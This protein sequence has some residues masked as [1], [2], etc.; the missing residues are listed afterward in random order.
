MSALSARTVSA[1]LLALFVGFAGCTPASPPDEDDEQN[2]GDPPRRKDVG[3][4]R[5]DSFTPPDTQFTDTEDPTRDT[6]DPP[7]S[8]GGFKEKLCA[9]GS[10]FFGQIG[11]RPS[12]KN[13][14]FGGTPSKGAPQTSSGLQDVIDEIKSIKKN[15]GGK[16]PTTT[17]M[18]GNKTPKTVTLGSGEK[19]QVDGAVVTATSFKSTNFDNGQKVFW[20]QDADTPMLVYLDKKLSSPTIRVGQRLNFTVTGVKLFGGTPEITKI[21]NVSVKKNAGDSV[22]YVAASGKDLSADDWAKVVRIGGQIVREKPKCPGLPDGHCYVLAHGQSNEKIE[23]RV[24]MGSYKLGDCVT[25]VGP[26]GL[27]PG[28]L[29]S[30]DKTVQLQEE[31]F[32]WTTLSN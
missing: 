22:P 12:K 19:V 9:P 32:D 28:P 8:S 25:F 1:S 10:S 14:H 31:N 20:L 3:D 21:S 7:D 29:A 6:S 5:E 15:N 2:G 18:K 13:P 26:L 16:W 23:F 27:F 30:G 4:Q 11:K 17:D 24:E